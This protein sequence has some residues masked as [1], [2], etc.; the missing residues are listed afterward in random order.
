MLKNFIPLITSFLIIA[1]TL[2]QTIPAHFKTRLGIKYYS[3]I[4]KSIFKTA[5]VGWCS[6]YSYYQ[7]L[8]EEVSWEVVFEHANYYSNEIPGNLEGISI[9]PFGLGKTEM[10]W[11]K[12][13]GTIFSYLIEKNGIPL[14]HTKE[15]SVL[16]NY[17]Y[18]RQLLKV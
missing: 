17:N 10:K 4:N 6:W 1:N 8:T 13:Y 7:E 15:L 5:P 9:K 3:P 14:G 2:G 12:K 18:S 16:L 11:E